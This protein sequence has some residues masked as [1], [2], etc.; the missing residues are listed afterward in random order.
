MSVRRIMGIETEYGISV[1]GQPRANA[2]VSSSRSSTLTAATTARA[3]RAR[4][5]FEEENPLR[6]AR[7]FDL[8]RRGWPTP[9]SDRRG[10]GPGQP[11][12]DQRRPA[13]RRPRPPGVLHARGAPTARRG[14]LGQGGRAGHGRGGRRAAAV[15]G[16]P[17]D[18]PLQEQH[19]QQGRVVRLPR[20][21]PDARGT[22]FAD[23]VRHLTPF[24]VSPPGGV[25]GRPGRASARTGATTVSSS[26][27][28]PTSSRSRSA[29]RRRSSGRSSTPATSRTPTRRSTAGC[30]SSS[31]T[32]T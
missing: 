25:R 1:P 18:Q 15:P 6:D 10:P 3:R 14:A 28:G 32:P 7:G 24:F 19:R 9:P 26:A 20:E 17:A 29:W 22:P 4:W 12:P 23:I 30:T 11:D 2:M 27:S 5:D 31:A 21:L 13:L 16:T 8:A